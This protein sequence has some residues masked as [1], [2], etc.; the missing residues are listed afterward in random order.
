MQVSPRLQQGSRGFRGR[1]KRICTNKIINPDQ[2][3]R[4]QLL[5]PGCKSEAVEFRCEVKDPKGL[6]EGT[7]GSGPDGRQSRKCQEQGTKQS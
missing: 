4:Q 2:C 7:G 1:P 6:E 5:Q 3:W